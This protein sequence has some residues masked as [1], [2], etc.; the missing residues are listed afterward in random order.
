MKNLHESGN[1]KFS[2]IA[3]IKSLDYAVKGFFLFLKNEH[4][5]IIHLAATIVVI[6]LCFLLPVSQME[7]TTVSF[8]IGLVWMAELFNTAIEKI[9]DFSTTEKLPPVKFIKDV[10]AAAVLVA[11]ITALVVG[12]IVFIPKL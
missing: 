4:N 10:S 1:I 3:R 11:S 8:A 6:V 9:M 5:A 7:I 2:I 12:C